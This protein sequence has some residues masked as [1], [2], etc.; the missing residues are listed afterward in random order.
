MVR[1]SVAPAA[2]RPD[3]QRLAGGLILLLLATTAHA[4]VFKVFGS[5]GSE[6]QFTPANTASPIARSRGISPDPWYLP[7]N[8]W[9]PMKRI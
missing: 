1:T 5:V 3:R 6:W 9:R 2:R 7:E 8:G 4:E